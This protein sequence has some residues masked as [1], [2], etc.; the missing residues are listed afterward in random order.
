[1]KPARTP[2]CEHGNAHTKHDIGGVHVSL[3]SMTPAAGVPCVECPLRR[4]STPGYLGGYSPELYLEAMRSGASLACHMTPG[5]KAND[6]AR[7]R[8]CTG[9]AA[10]RA[11]TGIVAMYDAQFTQAHESTRFV[12]S[13]PTAARTLGAVFDSEDSFMEHHRPG[14]DKP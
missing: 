13:L 7:Q 8:H 9:V 10:F 6:I 11:N 3:V 12:A 4:D 1:M 14:Q 5:F 2:T